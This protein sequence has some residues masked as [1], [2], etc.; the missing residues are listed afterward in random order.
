MQSERAMVGNNAAC[1]A[2]EG[3]A[4]VNGAAGKE[5]VQDAVYPYTEEHF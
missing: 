4:L 1:K 3:V 2:A 5:P